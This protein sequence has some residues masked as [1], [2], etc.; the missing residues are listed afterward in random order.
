MTLHEVST[1]YE[2]GWSELSNGELLDAAEREGFALLITTDANLR[3]QQ[4][5][6]A[7][8][9]AIVVLLATSWPRIQKALP[10]I[11]DAISAAKS[12]SYAEVGI[13]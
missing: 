7:R 4:N 11:A 1:A 3:Y 12:G 10:A 6:A 2:L 13:P 9:I 8:K 5:L